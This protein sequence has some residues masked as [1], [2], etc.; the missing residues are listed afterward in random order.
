MDELEIINTISIVKKMGLIVGVVFIFSIG[1]SYYQK[2]KAKK[3]NSDIDLKVKEM[4]E[5]SN[6]TYFQQFERINEEEKCFP[7][8]RTLK[9]VKTDKTITVYFSNKGFDIYNLGIEFDDVESIQIAPEDK[10]MKNSSGAI[11]IVLSSLIEENIIFEIKGSDEFRNQIIQ[12]YQL[13]L[14][15]KRLFE[16]METV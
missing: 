3:I 10:I 11:K 9:V 15:E 5:K 13:S 6:E 8:F 2:W 4:L 16:L 7:Q 1:F 12:K 14:S